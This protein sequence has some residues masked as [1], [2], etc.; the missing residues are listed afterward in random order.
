L[1]P[2]QQHVA[3]MLSMLKTG[4][5]ASGSNGEGLPRF[6]RRN[7]AM[8]QDRLRNPVLRSVRLFRLRY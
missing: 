5:V 8:M 2:D 1:L 7:D 3:R 6:S 4:A